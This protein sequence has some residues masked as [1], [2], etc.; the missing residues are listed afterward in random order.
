MAIGRKSLLL[1]EVT[2]LKTRF[3]RLPLFHQDGLDGTQE[4]IAE[5]EISLTIYV[6][7]ASDLVMTRLPS[8]GLYSV[9]TDTRT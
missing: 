8:L 9:I 4:M 3:L 6:P 7:G 1:L 2:D 5:L